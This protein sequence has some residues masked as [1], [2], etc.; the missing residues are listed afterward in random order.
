VGSEFLF[1]E[2]AHR[3]VD[4][5]D[6]IRRDFPVAVEIGA[7]RGGLR[8][9]LEGR[10]GIRTLVQIDASLAMIRQAAGP[11][12]VA[13]EELFPFAT[14]SVDL[15]VSNLALHWTNDL[16]GALAQ[17]RRAL[18]PDGLLLAA[19][20]GGDSLVELRAALA[21]AEIEA[22]G[23]LT[24]RL[25]PLVGVRDAGALLQR[26]GF[27]LPVVDIDRIT[28]SYADPLAL[29][30][31]LRAMGETNATAGRPHSLT[32]RDVIAGAA[33]RYAERHGD[34]EGR[35]PA[36]F[37]IIHLSGWAPD[38]SQPTPLRPGSGQ[39]SLTQVLG[40]EDG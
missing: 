13:D 12:L 10:N 3:L 39:V 26:A 29:M 36:T 9:R 8:P 5:L 6:D 25:S 19:L 40:D 11:R 2:V 15:V 28:V 37:D 20:I 4:R 30:H 21:D 34:A 14:H 33:L 27:A 24:P 16:P 18:R 31:D 32:R 23:G 1:E 38:A 7:R 22:V 35:I 17:V